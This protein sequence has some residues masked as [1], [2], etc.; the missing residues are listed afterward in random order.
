MGLSAQQLIF[1]LRSTTGQDGTTLPDTDNASSIGAM[2]FLNR[3]FWEIANKFNL[4]EEEIEVDVPTVIGTFNYTCPTLM[5]AVN[6]LSIL[7]PTTLTYARLEPMTLDVYRGLQNSNTNLRSRPTNYIRHG[8]SYLLYPTPDAVYSIKIDYLQTL[9][10]IIQAGTPV[11]PREWH[12]L[13]HYG[14]VW[15]VYSDVNG[16]LARSQYFR[17]LQ[18]SMLNSTVPVQSKE[19]MDY[20]NAGVNVKGRSY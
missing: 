2:T 18:T 4:R 9:A 1:S 12:E 15:R 20:S 19:E 8:S 7:N 5:D 6:H 11:I 3:S 17:N 16:D 13:I 14:A 10:D